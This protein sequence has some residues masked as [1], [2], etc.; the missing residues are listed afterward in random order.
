MEEKVLQSILENGLIESG[1][2]IV[3]GVSGGPDSI[4]L[5]HVLNNI[6]NN[7]KYNLNFE[8]YVCHIN[9]G[10][11]ENAVLDEKYVEEYCSKKSIPFYLKKVNIETIAK[12]E[13]KGTEETGRNV[14]YEFFEE[15]AIK[16][17]SNKIATAHNKN[18]NIETVIMNILRGSGVS[19]LK[20]IE[21]KRDK[22]IRPLI[23]ITREEI[24]EYCN[25]ESLNPRED[26]SNKENIYTRNKI[27]NIVIP[28]I[29]EQ[30]NPNIVEAIDRLSCMSKEETEYLDKIVE[31]EYKKIVK[32]DKP[33]LIVLD[34]QGFNK[35]EIVIKRRVIRYTI[36]RLIGTSLGIERIHVEDIVKLCNN[37]IGNKLLHPNKNI[38][39]M[40]KKGEI[41]FEDCREVYP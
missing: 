2:R 27:R 13:K 4:C 34:L 22:Y 3:I 20:G 24:E 26:E 9:H 30:F 39:I 10:I 41:F 11:R 25:K 18:D 40:L 12:Q 36:N 29:K 33:K 14:R 19:G 6:R 35:L 31:E 38:K 37:N 15:I 16:T 21:V 23:S 28:Y 7:V 5:L 17:G 8:L 1:D 32:V